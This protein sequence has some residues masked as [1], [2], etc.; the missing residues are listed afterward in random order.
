M[1]ETKILTLSEEEAQAAI[2]IWKLVFGFV[3][4]AVVKCAIELGIAEA[5]E[6]HGGSMTLTELSSTLSCSAAS[7][8]RIM[9]LLV[10]RKIFKQKETAHGSLAF[11]QTALSR[12]LLRQAENSM[13]GFILFESSPVM[14]AP[15]HG[16]RG[17][18]Q[19]EEASAFDA[20]HGEDVWSYAAENPTHSELLNEAMACNARMAMTAVINGCP[21]VFD[22]LSSVVDVGGGNGTALRMMIK[23]FPWINHGIN[24][25]LP[26]VVSAALVSDKVQ[27]V[28]GN[29]FDDIPKADAAF[30]MW[31]L[32]DWGDSE[33]IQILQKCKEAIPRDKGKIIIIEAVIGQNRDDKLEEARLMLDMVIMA[34]TNK[35]KERTLQEWKYV[36][37]KA[38]FSR[39]N[40]IPIHAVQSVI[41]VYP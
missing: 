3:E 7:L 20:A 12:H 32:H 16:L 39:F 22:G 36:I 19:A 2:D 18:V 26:H 24:F 6:E 10:H 31:V 35:G 14:L 17:R 37:N 29:M 38:G 1:E 4:M 25:D 40:V 27:H 11:C 15:W 8:L 41:E 33:C 21:Q 30:V 28:G 13:A 34:H 23:A 9:R 5:L